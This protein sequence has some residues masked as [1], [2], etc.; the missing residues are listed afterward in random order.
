MKIPM[1]RGFGHSMIVGKVNHTV[2]PFA[3]RALKTR[4]A[5]RLWHPEYAFLS[6]SADPYDLAIVT[7]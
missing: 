2:P 4:F 5:L 7:L 1:D 6:S 3:K